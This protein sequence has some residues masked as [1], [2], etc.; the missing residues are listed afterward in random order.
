MNSVQVPVK[1]QRLAGLARVES[2]DDGRRLWMAALR[3]LDLKAI[4][5]QYLSQPIGYWSPRTGGTWHSDQR[6]RCFQKPCPID[7][8]RHLLAVSR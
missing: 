4:R 2:D 1:L 8:F 3:P 7:S 6:F 5:S